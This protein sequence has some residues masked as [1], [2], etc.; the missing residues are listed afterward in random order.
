MFSKQNLATKE[1]KIMFFA[2]ILYF[3]YNNFLTLMYS[4]LCIELY[5]K[6]SQ[7]EKTRFDSIFHIMEI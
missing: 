2:D 5:T 6:M 3:M 1:K 4:I 7:E